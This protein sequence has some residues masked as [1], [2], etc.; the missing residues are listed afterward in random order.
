MNL[1]PDSYVFASEKPLT[2]LIGSHPM[3]ILEEH[4]KKS[5]IG[6]HAARIELDERARHAK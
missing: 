2:L 6:L 4:S 1:R 3:G 5:R